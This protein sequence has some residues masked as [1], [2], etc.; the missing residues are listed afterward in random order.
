MIWISIEI[1]IHIFN[2]C[3]YIHFIKVY[4]IYIILYLYTLHCISYSYGSSGISPVFFGTAL[5]FSCGVCQGPDGSIEGDCCDLL[6]AGGEGVSPRD[7]G[8]KVGRH[9]GKDGHSQ[10]FPGFWRGFCS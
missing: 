2:I 4:I 5:P 3:I 6:P 10:G 9:L 8:M 1:C 7:T